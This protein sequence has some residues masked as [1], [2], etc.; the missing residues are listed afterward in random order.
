MEAVLS[1]EP[2]EPI[3]KPGNRHCAPNGVFLRSMCGCRRS[4]RV[5]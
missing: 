1:I 2:M 4:L 5:N 3:P